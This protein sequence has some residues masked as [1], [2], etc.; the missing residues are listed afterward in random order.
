[1]EHLARRF[2]HFA[3]VEVFPR[4]VGSAPLTDADAARAAEVVRHM[5]P[6]AQSVVDAELARAMR[7][8]ATLLLEASVASLPGP[9]RDAVAEEL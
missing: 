3:A 5:R 1:M 6:L 2:V 9:V 8:E 7:H 4:Y